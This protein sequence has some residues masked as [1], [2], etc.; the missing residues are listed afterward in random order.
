MGMKKTQPDRVI[1]CAS[2]W[3]ATAGKRP[4]YEDLIADRRVVK[5]RLNYSVV[6]PQT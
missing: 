3:E 2:T 6:M 4:V 1:R 5:L